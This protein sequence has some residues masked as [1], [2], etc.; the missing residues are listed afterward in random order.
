MAEEE[1]ASV[2]R[3]EDQTGVKLPDG[4]SRWNTVRNWLSRIVKVKKVYNL[5]DYKG[6]NDFLSHAN[7]VACPSIDKSRNVRR[8]CLKHHQRPDF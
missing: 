4:K 3:N 5:F 2:G 6:T 8:M 1:V 7:L